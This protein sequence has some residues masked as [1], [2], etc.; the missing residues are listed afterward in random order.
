MR[1]V[2]VDVLCL[3]W[4]VFMIIVM[5]VSMIESVMMS[6]LGFMVMEWFVWWFLML[7]YEFVWLFDLRFIGICFGCVFF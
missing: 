4:F 1:V 5:V 7:I 6:G 3:V 2:C